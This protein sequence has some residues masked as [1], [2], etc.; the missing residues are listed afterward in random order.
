M[1]AGSERQD[2]TLAEGLTFEEGKLINKSLSALGNVVKALA[3]NPSGHIPYRNSKLTR[4]LQVFHS[5]GLY[6]PDATM[7]KTRDRDLSRLVGVHGW[8]EHKRGE[9]QQ[10]QQQQDP[11]HADFLSDVVQF[12]VAVSAGGTQESLDRF[13]ILEVLCLSW[14]LL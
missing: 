10:Q 7:G 6:N 1:S 3:D 12:H 2:K 14:Q 5:S 8:P 9:K 13:G 11:G 4:A